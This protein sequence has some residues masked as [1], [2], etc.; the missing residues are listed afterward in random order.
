MTEEEQERAW[1]YARQSSWIRRLVYAPFARRVVAL[2]PTTELAPTIVDLGCGPGQLAIQLG[3]L[4]PQAHLVGVDPTDEILRRARENASR[5]RLL[6]FEVRQGSAEELPVESGS[7]DLVISQSSFHEWEDPQKGLAEIIR[8]LRP[9]GCLILKDYNLDWLSG[10]KGVL[11]GRLHPLHMFKFGAQEVTVLLKQAGFER[12]E[13]R[14][15]GLQ[16]LVCAYK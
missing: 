6:N 2:L 7:V 3:R 1:R 12:I 14:S 4:R 10:W 15:S 11:L 13:V 9:G 5:A 8:I 16:Y